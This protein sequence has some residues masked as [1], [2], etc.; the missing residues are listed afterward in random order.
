MRISKVLLALAATTLLVAGCAKKEEPANQAVASVEAALSAVR[1]DAAKYA[2]AE[3]RTAEENLAALKDKLAKEKYQDALAGAAELQKEVNTLKEVSVSRQTQMVAATREWE[4][5]SA[6]VPKMVEAIQTRV[7][8]LSGSPRLPK[9]VSKEAF[10][11]AK[12]GLA[13]M[14]SLWAE[15]GSAFSAG[16]A[17][18]AADKARMVQAKGEEVIAQLGMNAA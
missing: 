5:L 7:D 11:A 10:E 3:L 17:N 9:N 1:D 2:P 16:R 13:S 14:K 18:E 12:A 4:R 15:A 6:D 8:T